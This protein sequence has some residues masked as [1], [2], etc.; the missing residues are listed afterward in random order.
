[1]FCL[2]DQDYNEKS[3]EITGEKFGLI[4]DLSKVWQAEKVVNCEINFDQTNTLMVETDEIT[5]YNCWKN[6]IIVDRFER[7]DVWPMANDENFRDQPAILRS[8]KEGIFDILDNCQTD[9]QSYLK[10]AK[11]DSEYVRKA[12]QL[13]PRGDYEEPEEKENAVKKVEKVKKPEVEENVPEKITETVS[14]EVII[15]EAAPEKTVAEA[16]DHIDSGVDELTKEM[17]KI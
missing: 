10:D 14:K 11:F 8:I 1:M 7:R 15:S 16:E 3:P 5:V 17:D 6:S 4:R 12:K 13:E 9:I 2:F